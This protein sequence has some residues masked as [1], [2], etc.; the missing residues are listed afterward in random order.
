MK[1]P[2]SAY[3]G[4][5][6][7][8]RACSRHTLD[9]YRRDVVQFARFTRRLVNGDVDVKGLDPREV[10]A[11][12]V[13]GGASGLA[14]SSVARKL[15]CLK[16]FFKYLVRSDVIDVNPAAGLRFP[17][18]RRKLPG[19]LS[20]TEVERLFA[21]QA[22]DFA[23]CRDLAILELLYGS[24]IRVGELVALN[25][26]DL[27]LSER[28]VRVSG[29]GRKERVVPFGAC[30]AA[31][32]GR[33]CA[34]RSDR[35]EGLARFRGRPGREAGA[36]LL[37]LRGVRLTVRSVQRIVAQRLAGAA[38]EKSVSPHVLRH[39]FATHL[40]DAGADLRAVQELLGHSSIVTTQ[41]YTH[42]S[43]RRLKEAYVKAH[44]R[45]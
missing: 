13:H 44:P 42:V 39:S 6:R 45:A 38:K 34:F 3:I 33:Y 19:F 23:S 24:G 21:F 43:L 11:F 18:K 29:K 9:S 16:S 8:Q 22:R 31:A 14:D 1:R 32:L 25:L 17:R 5:L 12:L 36:L 37:S 28:L 26:E 30:A 20:V 35:L 4:Y 7:D 15:A 10:R 40:L 41:I 2:L 27:K